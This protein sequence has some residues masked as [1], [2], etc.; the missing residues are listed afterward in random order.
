MTFDEFYTRFIGEILH[1]KPSFIRSGQAL[2]NFLREIWPSEYQRIVN[3]EYIGDSI[4]CFYNDTYISKTFKHL[5][6]VWHKK[7]N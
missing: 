1:E 4:D 7:P 3:G 2:M 5:Q 6:S